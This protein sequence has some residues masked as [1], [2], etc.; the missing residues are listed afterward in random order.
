M[1]EGV[2]E[3]GREGGREGVL[4]RERG[5]WVVGRGL[6]ALMNTSC[7]WRASQ[8]P[9]HSSPQ[10]PPLTSYHY[11]SFPHNLLFSSFITFLR[12]FLKSMF[13]FSGFEYCP[14]LTLA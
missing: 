8:R 7:D 5:G 12:L 9:C 6:M 4:M 10:S 13:V 14:Q 11:R 3:G 1:V 2:P